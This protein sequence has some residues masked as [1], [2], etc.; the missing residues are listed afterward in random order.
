FSIVGNKIL[1]MGLPLPHKLISLNNSLVV[2]SEFPFIAS[3]IWI[4]SF[5]HRFIESNG[6]FKVIFL[7]ILNDIPFFIQILRQNM[8]RFPRIPIS[9]IYLPKI[10]YFSCPVGSI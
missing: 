10:S 1:K 3:Y 4:W 9:L 2:A 7:I 8:L 6:N 5:P